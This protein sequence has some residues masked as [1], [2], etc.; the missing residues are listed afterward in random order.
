MIIISAHQKF[1]LKSR[2]KKLK[3]FKKFWT[4]G[5]KKLQPVIKCNTDSIISIN[6]ILNK[7]R[8][9]DLK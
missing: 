1:K 8:I 7:K 9:K 5:L 4:V 3:S 2:L 6:A